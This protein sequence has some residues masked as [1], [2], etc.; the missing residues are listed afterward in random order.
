MK[1]RNQTAKTMKVPSIGKVGKARGEDK[2]A[3]RGMSSRKTR[4][5]GK[6]SKHGGSKECER[7]DILGMKAN[8]KGE[9]NRTE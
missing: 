3:R 9:E 2:T 5:E 6:N 4:E 7:R 1:E 8:G